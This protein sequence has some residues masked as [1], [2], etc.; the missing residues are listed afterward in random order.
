MAG[1]VNETL[2]KQEIWKVDKGAAD[3]KKTRSA[4]SALIKS[5]TFKKTYFLYGEEDYLI[6][7][8][9]NALIKAIAGDNDLNITYFEGEK[10]DRDEFASILGTLPFFAEKRVVVLENSGLFKQ[11]KNEDKTEEGEDDKTSEIED[12]FADIPDTTVLIVVDSKV[13][14]TKKLVKN[15]LKDGEAFEIKYQDTEFIRTWLYKKFKDAG[16][17]ITKEAGNLLIDQIGVDM[18]TLSGEADKL[19]AYSGGKPIGVND[20]KA[21]TS[22]RFENKVFTVVEKAVTGRTEEALLAYKDVLALNAEPIAIL[23]LMGKQIS[24]YLAAIEIY[25]KTGNYNDVKAKL[26]ISYFNKIAP[27]C[28]KDKL[29]KALER[30]VDLDRSIKEGNVDMKLAPELLIAYLSK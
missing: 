21:V 17:Y 9:K 28:N 5:S 20:I 23:V 16:A 3:N 25:N 12:L 11:K 7:Y 29:E 8:Y 13:T 14:K 27:Y 24:K 18:N 15:L 4:L 10:F 30:Y 6:R 26:N 22:D 2:Q 1:F 19:I